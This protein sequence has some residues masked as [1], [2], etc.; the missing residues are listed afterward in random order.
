MSSSSGFDPASLFALDAAAAATAAAHAAHAPLDPL[1]NMDLD[2]ALGLEVADFALEEHL[3]SALHNSTGPTSALTCSAT[4]I[5]AILADLDD[6]LDLPAPEAVPA[7]VAAAL[8][9][10]D[11]AAPALDNTACPEAFRPA[12]TSTSALP[13]A[14]APKRAHRA[15]RTT[16]KRTAAAAASVAADASASDGSVTAEGLPRKRRKKVAVAEHLKDDAYW[17]YRRVNNERARRCREK[18]R[19]EKQQQKNRLVLLDQENQ[20]LR[21]ELELLKESLVEL[22]MQ[23]KRKTAGAYAGGEVPA[24]LAELMAHQDEAMA[25]GGLCLAN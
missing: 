25:A 23:L 7:P 14:K 2:G 19:L 12:T 10:Q 16:A 5:D 4:D 22:C 6:T 18:K 9:L 3:L 8:Q 13:K 24:D 17:E 1:L 11:M 15:R 20:E 21:D